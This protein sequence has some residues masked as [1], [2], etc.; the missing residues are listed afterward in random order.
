MH[1]KVLRVGMVDMTETAP[2]VLEWIRGHGYRYS[3][4]STQRADLETVSF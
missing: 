3:H 4:L 2:A 1:E